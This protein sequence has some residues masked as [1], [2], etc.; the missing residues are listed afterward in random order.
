[1]KGTF[2]SDHATARRS[3]GAGATRI[4]VLM[5]ASPGRDDNFV[6]REISEGLSDALRRMG[7]PGRLQYEFHRFASEV[8][9]DRQTLIEDV[10]AV[11]VVPFTRYCVEFLEQL[12]SPEVPVVA[13][14]DRIRSDFISNFYIEHERA[15]TQVTE[16]LLRLGHRRIAFVTDSVATTS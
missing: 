15:A 14:F 9:Y 12:R 5:D 13:L 11:L 1:G 8:D 10:D 7:V 4:R 6:A 3:N 16:L 2:V